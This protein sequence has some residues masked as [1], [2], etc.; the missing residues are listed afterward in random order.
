MGSSNKYSGLV[1]SSLKEQA[2]ALRLAGFS[3]QE[4]AQASDFLGAKL[5]LSSK[6]KGHTTDKGQSLVYI[7]SAE[8]LTSRIKIESSNQCNFRR[9]QG[10]ESSS[11]QQDQLYIKNYFLQKMDMTLFPRR[12]S[13]HA[14]QHGG[15][16]VW[17]ARLRPT[18]YQQVISI[19]G[20][21]NHRIL[22]AQVT[23]L[24]F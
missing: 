6:L 18:M 8:V 24:S 17:P 22:P 15:K 16:R 11:G 21:L 9:H 13:G 4:Q 5:L 7:L 2:T 20:K 23:S 10:I 3:L 1:G 14:H 19:I 12:T